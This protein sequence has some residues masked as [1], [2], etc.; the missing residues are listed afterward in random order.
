VGRGGPG[1]DLL[2]GEAGPNRLF[3]EAV[4]DTLNGGVDSGIDDCFG[5]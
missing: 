2:E 3:G 4:D 1:D 5:G